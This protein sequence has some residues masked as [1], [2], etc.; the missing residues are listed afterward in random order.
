MGG[1]NATCVSPCR[2]TQPSFRQ[3]QLVKVNVGSSW[4]RG[5]VIKAEGRS[6]YRVAF[7]DERGIPREIVVSPQE[8][9]LK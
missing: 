5:N 7:Q 9:R 1:P 4:V 3:G 8:I 2:S 6:M